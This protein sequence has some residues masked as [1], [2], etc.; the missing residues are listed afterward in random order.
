MRDEEPAH[1]F[2]RFDRSDRED[3]FTLPASERKEDAA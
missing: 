2:Q 1:L 3:A